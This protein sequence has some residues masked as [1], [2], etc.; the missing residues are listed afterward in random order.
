MLES[1]ENDDDE[2]GDL[3]KEEAGSVVVILE[4]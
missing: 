2:R 3:A 4:P 1:E